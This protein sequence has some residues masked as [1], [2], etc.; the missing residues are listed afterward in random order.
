MTGEVSERGASFAGMST[1]VLEKAGDGPPILLLHGFAD[2]ADTWRPLL[3]TMARDGRRVIAVDLPLFG[4]AHRPETP[5]ML[6]ML[7]RFTAAFVEEQSGGEE[8]VVVG[9]S[10][11]GLLSMRAASDPALP[12]AGIVPIGPAGMGLQPW[13][14]AVEWVGAALTAAAHTPVPTS[15]LQRAAGELFKVLASSDR[16]PSESIAHFSSHI[17]RG[18]PARLMRLARQMLVELKHP[19]ALDA[20]R[21]SC[22]VVLV[23]G[24]K[25]KLCPPAGAQ[26]FID[27]VPHTRLE[28]LP[29]R[30]HC[31]QLED[32][33]RIRELVLGIGAARVPRAA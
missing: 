9:N 28:M 6:E 20:G 8:V 10:L 16:L 13:V 5:P 1:R 26:I 7:D 15:V 33:H 2:S 24:G 25:D 19:S 29:A 11:G 17:G 12:I 30:G 27:A 23:W 21:I 32:P 14:G 18:D 31:V 3:Q 22:E 4:K